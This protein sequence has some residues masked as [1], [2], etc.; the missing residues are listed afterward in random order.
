PS[1]K[2]LSVSRPCG[3]TWCWNQNVAPG[4]ILKLDRFPPSCQATCPVDG[5]DGAVRGVRD[6]R[7][8]LSGAP[9]DLPFPPGEHG[10][11]LVALDLEIH[12]PHALAGRE[13]GVR[14]VPDD[15]VAPVQDH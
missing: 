5:G 4:P 1:S 3:R 7:L 13:P 8:A 2:M 15:A 9:D 6:D 12:P 11:A 10:V 14:R